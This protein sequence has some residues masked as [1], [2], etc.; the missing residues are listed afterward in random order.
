M[1]GNTGWVKAHVAHTH[2]HTHTNTL[3]PET[4]LVILHLFGKHY[5]YIG[6]CL[7]NHPPKVF[8]RFLQWPLGGDVCPLATGNQPLWFLDAQI[9]E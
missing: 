2:T 3:E 7:A 5:N 4:Y 9:E 6:A 1:R 8:H